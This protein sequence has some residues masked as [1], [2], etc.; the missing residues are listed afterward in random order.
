MPNPHAIQIRHPVVFIA[1]LLLFALV[2]FPMQAL[3]QAE[4]PGARVRTAAIQ[5]AAEITAIDKNTREITLLLPHGEYQTLVAGPDVKRFDEFQVGDAIVATYVTSLAGE[6]RDPTP[7]ELE[8]PWQEL[9]AA[10]V[11][12]LDLPPGV[13]GMR[14]VKAVCTIEGMNRVAGTAMIKDP[15]GKYHLI[16]DIPPERFEG[17]KLGDTVVMVYTQALAL[18]LEKAPAGDE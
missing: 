15:R 3:S 17:R 1:G 9:D 5:I 7:E 4:D 2:I 8:N 18:T 13:A 6:V 11:A 12:N 10:A 16:G 14:V